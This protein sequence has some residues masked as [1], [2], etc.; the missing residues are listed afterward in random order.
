MRLK[1][2]KAL[3]PASKERRPKQDIPSE[4]ARIKARMARRPSKSGAD[5]DSADALTKPEPKS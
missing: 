2:P 3:F 4:A 1:Q 5:I